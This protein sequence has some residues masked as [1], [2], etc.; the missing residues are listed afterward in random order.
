MAPATQRR[1]VLVPRAFRAV[2]ERLCTFILTYDG[3]G[4]PSSSFISLHCLFA[5]TIFM[6]VTILRYLPRHLSGD[7][8]SHD[9]S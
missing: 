8:R 9:L 7:V 4:L 1:A 5:S 6:S 3:S 2:D